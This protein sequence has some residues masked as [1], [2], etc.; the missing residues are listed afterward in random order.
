MASSVGRHWIVIGNGAVCAVPALGP[1]GLGVLS[2]SVI[3]RSDTKRPTM[4]TDATARS[5]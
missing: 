5:R 2:L 1:E 3:E 4:G